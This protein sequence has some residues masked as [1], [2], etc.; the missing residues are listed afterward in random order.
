[1]A[2]ADGVAEDGPEDLALAVVV[3]GVEVGRVD[4][5]LWDAAVPALPLAGSVLLALLLL[6][7]LASKPPLRSPFRPLS[8]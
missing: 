5:L 3:A 2:L 1:M 7:G 6:A 4:V 8:S